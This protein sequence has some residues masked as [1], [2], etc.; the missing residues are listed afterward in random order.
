MKD[1]A[2]LWGSS[3]TSR[4][5]P[6]GGRAKGRIRFIPLVVGATV[7]M[8]CYAA[9]GNAAAPPRSSCTFHT[10]IGDRTRRIR[11]VSVSSV[12]GS[13]EMEIS[14]R[15]G[16]GRDGDGDNDAD[17]RT[18]ERLSIEIK[19]GG[20]PYLDAE[21]VREPNAVRTRLHFGR[22]FSGIHEESFIS[23]GAT[24][25]GTI[26]GRRFTSSPDGGLV[27]ADGK[28]A[29]IIRVDEIAQHDAD[30]LLAQARDALSACM[31]DP[32]ETMHPPPGPPIIFVPGCE[33]CEIDC[34]NKYFK[35]LVDT[36]QCPKAPPCDPQAGF[37][38]PPCIDPRTTCTFT[39]HS[40]VRGCS[41]GCD[42]CCTGGT[43]CNPTTHSCDRR[44]L[45][46]ARKTLEILQYGQVVFGRDLPVPYNAALGA[47][48]LGL[49][50]L[51][52]L[53]N[54]ARQ[55]PM[56]VFFNPAPGA[57][58]FFS[59]AEALFFARDPE[60]MFQTL[61]ALRNDDAAWQL[62]TTGC[63]GGGCPGP[64]PVIP[65]ALAVASPTQGGVVPATAI[66]ALGTFWNG[67]ST[68]GPGA[69]PGG[70]SSIKAV[71][72]YHHGVCATEQPIQK[73][74][75]L[76]N[77]QFYTN[78]FKPGRVCSN[79]AAFLDG[80]IYYTNLT[81]YLTHSEGVQSDL[82]G[83]F[84]FASDIEVI[85][86][87]EGT[88]H[89]APCRINFNMGYE[90]GLVDGRLAVTQISNNSINVLNQ[91]ATLCRGFGNADEVPGLE[92]VADTALLV[93]LPN[94]F[95]AAASL[96][97]GYPF[98]LNDTKFDGCD[99]NAQ[100]PCAQFY[101]DGTLMV[102]MVKAGTRN[103]GL[104]DLTELPQVLNTLRNPANWRCVAR[105]LAPPNTG[106][107]RNRCEY[108]V[109]AKRFN[110]TPDIG[111]LVWFD[112]ER[113][114]DAPAIP[115]YYFT[116]GLS[117]GRGSPLCGRVPNRADPSLDNPSGAVVFNRAFANVHT[118]GQ[119]GCR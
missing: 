84:L 87:S 50:P 33:E 27:F 96:Q 17:D 58:Y 101:A 34:S 110:L 75:N 47:G 73:A 60:E 72:V 105:D 79:P 6:G 65:A 45:P 7:V 9:G 80:N 39:L 18:R 82:R 112:D 94:Q 24:T 14:R 55:S 53:T 5:E 19:T 81:S 92:Q 97:Q 51:L 99:P 76:V 22:A 77:T 31:T 85:D 2:T 29:P 78:F 37:C 62:N 21:T 104:D 46:P 90:I 57:E 15:D 23:D 48:E 66:A 95:N 68:E 70:K 36:P 10:D 102:N 59:Q 98:D 30:A 38:P 108:I 56:T 8:V 67:A 54:V 52:Q 103:R 93:T 11:E 35:C 12:A 118:F 91:N 49:V 4:P 115:I 86:L 107:I 41:G 64:L 83:G 13:I 88:F 100:N 106:H 28:P 69:D 111:E 26:D 20:V 117:L 32:P 74:L 71:R 3:R 116:Q 42:V 109:R 40:C 114:F 43:D 89:L 25:T 44:E 61:A 119:L 1:R 16:D 63:A 113:E